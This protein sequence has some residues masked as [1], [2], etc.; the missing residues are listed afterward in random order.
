MIHV[1]QT[2]KTNL[3]EPKYIDLHES[4]KMMF[5]VH[6]KNDTHV[7][8]DIYSYCELK[9][10]FTLCKK[11]NQMTM[12]QIVDIWRYVNAYLNGGIYADIDIG[13]N[14]PVKLTQL[15]KKCN[16]IL[17]RESP[18]FLNNPLKYI[19]HTINYL[20]GLS[21]RARFYQFRQSIFYS[22]TYHP[23][24]DLILMQIS[25]INIDEL[26]K[27]FIEPRLTYE[28]TGPGI[29]TDFSNYYTSIPGTCIIEYNDGLQI[30]DYHHYGTWKHSFA[31]VETALRYK[32]LLISFSIL[33]NILFCMY[34]I[35][36]TRIS[37]FC[38]KILTILF[39]VTMLIL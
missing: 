22:T 25:E 19:S 9:H 31:D 33:I 24:F 6:L 30:L 10:D 11:I 32:D 20:I 1:Y 36:Y 21:N 23:L 4:W 15:C 18:S 2:W 12:I 8:Q 29:F 35:C 14:N 17:I 34:V 28:L 16:L 3:L 13:V 39:R 26:K 27:R 5:N 7:F 38:S 37:L